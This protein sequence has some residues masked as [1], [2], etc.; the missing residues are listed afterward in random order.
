MLT[1][2]FLILGV[3]QGCANVQ[4]VIVT[5]MKDSG[6]VETWTESEILGINAASQVMTGKSFAHANRV[7]KLTLQALWQVLLPK[8]HSY[9]EVED[10]ELD[11][12]L[13]ATLDMND[14][15]EIVEIVEIVSSDRFQRC[16]KSFVD[17]ISK[18]NPTNQF[19]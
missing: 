3:L 15:V 1:F 19:W 7:N 12:L 2:F 6:L 16:M 18:D 14:V 10:A 8:L 13:I 11:E 9:L 4:G 17:F 5:H